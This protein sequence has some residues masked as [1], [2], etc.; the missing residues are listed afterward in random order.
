MKKIIL[1]AAVLMLAAILLQQPRTLAQ[2]QDAQAM[3]ASDIALLAGKIEELAR[4]VERKDDRQLLQKLDQVLANQQVILKEL[5][6]V[7][8]RATR[9]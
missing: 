7:K 4:A 1:F 8:V 6:I 2:R 5:E 9:K 3:Y